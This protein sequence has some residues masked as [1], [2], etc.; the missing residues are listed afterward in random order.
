MSGPTS[1]WRALSTD[2]PMLGVDPASF[3]D[4]PPA[5]ILPVPTTLAFNHQVGSFKISSLP[6][7]ARFNTININKIVA[8]FRHARGFPIQFDA[9]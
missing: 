1:S 6:T 2:F 8:M 4:G 5:G 9:S 7:D 3:R